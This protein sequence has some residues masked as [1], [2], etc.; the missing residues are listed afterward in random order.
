L[1]VSGFNDADLAART[2][3]LNDLSDSDPSAKH[4]L[5]TIRKLAMLVFYGAPAA[6]TWTNPNW[7][8]IGYPGPPST[9]ERAAGDRLALTQ[10]ADGEVLTADACVVGSGAGGSVVA[11]E[12]A[13]AGLKVIVLEQGAY[14]PSSEFDQRELLGYQNLWLNAGLAA[15]E[16]G[17]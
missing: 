16:D 2:Q 12:L 1:S 15:T 5:R 4:G 7:A 3:V 17:S 13:A 6:S 11:S 9:G 8:A 14:I 10:P